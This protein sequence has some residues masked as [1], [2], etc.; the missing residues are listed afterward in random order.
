MSPQPEISKTILVVDDDQVILNTLVLILKSRGYKPM[1][2]RDGPETLAC[3]RRE[4][5]DLILL[6]LMFP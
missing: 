5:P 6:D 4:K 3:I 2:A 1:I